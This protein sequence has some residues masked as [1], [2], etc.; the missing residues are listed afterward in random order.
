MLTQV[1]TQLVTR[2]LYHEWFPEIVYDVHQM[3]GRG[4]RLF[5]PPF[6][7]PVNPNLDPALVA[8]TNADQ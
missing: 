4:E 3:G 7:D 2:V 1:E 6:A 8:A 5:L